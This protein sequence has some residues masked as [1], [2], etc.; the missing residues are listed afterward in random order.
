MNF[1]FQQLNSHAE[2]L[3]FRKKIILNKTYRDKKRDHAERAY[4][5]FLH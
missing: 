4:T 5:Q 1:Q 3:D 2:D